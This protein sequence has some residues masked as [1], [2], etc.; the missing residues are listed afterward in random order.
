MLKAVS[1][2]A[3]TTPIGPA[4]GDLTGTYPNPTIISNVNLAGSP[5]TTT[6][7]TG[8]SSTK[9]ATTAFVATT[10]GSPVKAQSGVNYTYLTGDNH[11]TIVRSN[12]G[13]AMTDTLPQAGSSFLDGWYIYVINND[14][15]GTCL[16]TV[17]TSTING[18]TSLAVGPGQS[19]RIISDGTNYSGTL[20]IGTLGQTT[21]AGFNAGRALT[22]GTPNT[23]IGYN[24][25][26]AVSSGNS[27]VLIGSTAGSSLNTAS[28]N[29]II[30]TAAGTSGTTA[31]NNT[32]IG[33]AANIAT[34]SAYNI[35][36]GSGAIA[37]GSNQLV[38]GS[39][40]G[41]QG[42]TTVTTARTAGTAAGL[43]ILPVGYL[44]IIL[45]GTT[46]YIPYYS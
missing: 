1:L 19:V 29:V 41:G 43:P 25:G 42:I 2:L 46:V 39:N 3:G 16:I 45:N 31:N 6:Q 22:T 40:I 11:K 34:A 13:A 7:T 8:D 4:G 9:I 37:S 5:T 38:I 35:V 15:S 44:Q 33:Y 36:L 20:T 14:A 26:L 32:V 18:Q 24:A 30:G 21:L 17:T 27:N 12:S 23:F 28:Q 10:A